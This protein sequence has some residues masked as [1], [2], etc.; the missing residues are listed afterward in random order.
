MVPEVSIK[1]VWGIKALN[2]H[3]QQAILVKRYGYIAFPIVRDAVA[4]C[5]I[6][7]LFIGMPPTWKKGMLIR[8]MK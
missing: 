3:N 6:H 8:D 7:S 5:L 1:T 2:D 4:K